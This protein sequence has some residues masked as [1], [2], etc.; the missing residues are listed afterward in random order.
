[1]DGPGGGSIWIV[2]WGGA[3]EFGEGI[4][5]Y[6][7]GDEIDGLQADNHCTDYVVLRGH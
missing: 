5:R 2:N 4:S 1:M 3:E 7:L 6:R